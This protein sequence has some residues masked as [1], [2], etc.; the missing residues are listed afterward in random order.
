MRRCRW[1]VHSATALLVALV[2]GASFPAAASRRAIAETDLFSFGWIAD[3]RMSPDGRAVAFVAVKVNE[4]K[5]GY[6]TSIWFSATDGSSGRRL[7]SGPR[8]TA[9]RWSPDGRWFAFLRPVEKDGR[10]DPQIHLLSM[11]GGEARALTDLPRGTGAP[12]WSP[13]GTALAFTAVATDR[14]LAAVRKSPGP[15][16]GEARESDVRVITRAV[17]RANGGGYIAPQRGLGDEDGVGRNAGASVEAHGRRCRRPQPRV[18]AGRGAPLL[19]LY[20]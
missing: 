5:D 7:T 2:A 19:H 13:D 9:P 16:A 20:P 15:G 8:D 6:D 10:T 18:D 3:P 4:K 17:Y 14:D 11:Q 1:S 12:V